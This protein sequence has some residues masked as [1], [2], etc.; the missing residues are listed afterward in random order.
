MTIGSLKS[1]LCRPEFTIANTLSTT[2]GSWYVACGTFTL[3]FGTSTMIVTFTVS[4][5][6]TTPNFSF[7]TD[8]ALYRHDGRGTKVAPLFKND[9]VDTTVTPLVNL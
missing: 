2:T 5:S 3:F 8:T 4:N 9:A 6:T 7:G 1:D